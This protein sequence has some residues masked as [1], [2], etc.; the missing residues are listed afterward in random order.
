MLESP[1]GS[2]KTLA[3]LCAT[4]AWQQEELAKKRK[5][6]LENFKL[7][8][9]PVNDGTFECDSCNCQPKDKNKDQSD[10]CMILTDDNDDDEDDDFKP[11]PTKRKKGDDYETLP[12][13]CG[14]HQAI[15]KLVTHSEAY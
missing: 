1:T 6:D 13:E 12:C 11:M 7:K 10:D 9:E 5:Y 14:C 2:G 3:L 4:L 8:E 15:P